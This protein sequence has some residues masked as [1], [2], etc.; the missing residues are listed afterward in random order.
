M[1]GL[2]NLCQ[3]IC[4]QLQISMENVEGILQS[5]SGGTSGSIT[6]TGDSLSL[7]PHRGDGLSPTSLLALLFVFLFTI[8]ILG[9]RRSAP[10]VTAVNKPPG[11]P[12]SNGNP[13]APPP[14]D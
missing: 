8:T 2:M 6:H 7:P 9:N 4:Q 14:V 3:C 11:P 10:A 13:P 1:S 5:I 12:P